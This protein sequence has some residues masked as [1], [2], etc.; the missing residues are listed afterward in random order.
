MAVLY[1]NSRFEAPLGYLSNFSDLA[2]FRCAVG[3]ATWSFKTA[4]GAYQ[5][6]KGANLGIEC[7]SRFWYLDG[8]SAKKE[9]GRIA[10]PSDWEDDKIDAMHHVLTAKFAVSDYRK[11]LLDT[12]DHELVHYCPWG[13]TFWGVSEKNP[14]VGLN[15]L[16]R[17]LM[18][19]RRELQNEP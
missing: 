1:F 5:A 16:G 18:E 8:P 6:L 12:L 17:L 14:R 7:V 4:E 13:D 19:V 10:L 15:V 2:P 11:V 9:G 3:A